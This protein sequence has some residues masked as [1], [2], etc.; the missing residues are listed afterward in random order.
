[1]TSRDITFPAA[2]LRGPVSTT[3]DTG[4]PPAGL[5]D[6]VRVVVPAALAAALARACTTQMDEHQ[7]AAANVAAARRV[8][9]GCAVM[10]PMGTARLEGAVVVLAGQHGVD[11]GAEQDRYAAEVEPEDQDGHPSEAPKVFP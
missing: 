7:W 10:I 4:G 8:L 3:A 2:D 6:P 5:A 1:M 11:L 9:A